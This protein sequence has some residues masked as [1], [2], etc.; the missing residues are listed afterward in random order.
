MS[1]PKVDVVI[2]GCGAAGGIMAKEL[3]TNG[4]KVVALD[5]GDFLRTRDCAQL[6][7]LRYQ[8]RGELQHPLLDDT[9]VQWRPNDQTDTVGL[10]NMMASGIGGS[11]RHYT[12]Q[13]WRMLPHHF[14][15][16]SENV[17]RYG[18][19]VIPKDTSIV[20]WPM[21]YDDLAPFY[22]K[23]DSEIGISGKAGNINGIIQPGGNP[24]EG[25]R[26]NDYPMPPLLESTVSRLVKPVL[27]EMGYNPFPGPS[28]IAT[29]NYKGRPACTYCSFCSSYYCF[30]GAKG[31]TNVTVLPIGINSGNLEIRPNVRVIK[32]NK[33]KDGNKATGVTYLDADGNQ[34]EQLASMVIVSSY[35]YENIRLLLYSDI[36]KNDMVGK[37]FM[38]HHYPFVW[39]YFD[40]TITNPSTGPWAANVA[41]DN[42]NGDNFDHTGLGFIEGG[43]MGPY[44]G[45][46]QAIAG[47]GAGFFGIPMPD[48]TPT[49]GEGYK[50]ALKKYFR[51]VATFMPQIPSLPYDA[52]YCDL[53]PTVKDEIGMPVLRI[54]Y[55]AYENEIKAGTYLQNIIEDIMTKMEVSHIKKAGVFTPPSTAHE[56]GGVRMGTD[57]TKSVV[58]K[59]LQSWELPNMF[60]VGGAVFPTFFGYNPTHTIEALAFWSADYIKTQ[61]KP[62]GSLVQY[63]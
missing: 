1:L 19:S 10:A 3:S 21:S 32:I 47:S 40:N 27:E 44:G 22:D 25:P 62:G 37:Y 57:P 13:H 8:S 52:N 41:I 11:T 61:C 43:V 30:I 16:Y 33:D 6:D 59:Y 12:T 4:M 36:N 63:F 58:N 38:D 49:F 39:G 34:Q 35:T 56:V 18:E 29:E 51:R 60:V 42:F 28:S 17:G 24:F 45:N 26:S 7:E 54:T 14:K 5:R 2:V 9:K 20:D 53:D 50:Q 46:L 15:Q 48:G 55:N 31:S 23:V